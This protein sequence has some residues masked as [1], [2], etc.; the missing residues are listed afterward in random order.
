MHDA[1]QADQLPLV[2]ILYRFLT[3]VSN[4]YSYVGAH[5]SSLREMMWGSSTITTTPCKEK[6]NRSIPEGKLKH[7]GSW[8]KKQYNL[9]RYSGGGYWSCCG[10][11][12][13]LVTSCD[14][15]M[16]KRWNLFQIVVDSSTTKRVVRLALAN[17]ARSKW[18]KNLT[19]KWHDHCVRVNIGLISSYPMVRTQI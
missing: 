4:R 14:A 1:D 9:G 13:K 5:A 2:Q 10:N 15:I 3:T 12:D 7:P 19:V 6:T 8:R 18:H 16:Q 11:S 17:G